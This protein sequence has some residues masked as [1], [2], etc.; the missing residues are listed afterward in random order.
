MGVQGLKDVQKSHAQA[1]MT[2]VTQ[3]QNLDH[4][5][6][7]LDG[8]LKVL[9]EKEIEEQEYRDNQTLSSHKQKLEGL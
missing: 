3:S 9:S 1:P 2:V 8:K 4:S 7:K 5:L 6:N